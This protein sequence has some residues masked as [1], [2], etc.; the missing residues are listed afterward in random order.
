[1]FKPDFEPEI[2]VHFFSE[3]HWADL[4]TTR[5]NNKCSD[6]KFVA[7]K[8]TYAKPFTSDTPFANYDKNMINYLLVIHHLL[9]A[10][11]I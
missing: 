6:V 10:I 5:Y 11:R 1:M 4:T 7:V 8:A 3:E 2:E 9:T